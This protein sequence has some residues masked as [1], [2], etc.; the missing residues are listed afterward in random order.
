MH[1]PHYPPGTVRALLD[2]DLITPATREVIKARL[3]PRPAADPHFFDLQTFQTLRAV[4]DRLV[5]QGERADP[6]DLAAALDE[7]L[8]GGMCDGWRYASMPP[9]EDAYVRGLHGINEAAQARFGADF[10]TLD[11]AQ[12]D[13]VLLL[14]QRGDVQGT[15]WDTLPAARF[16]EELLAE[17][18]ECYYS[19]PLTHEEI[20]YVGMA[21]AH[22]W[23]AIALNQRAAHEPHALDTP[24]DPA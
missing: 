17:L 22:G 1:P 3:E 7:R 23:Q 13:Q 14:V 6:V 12:Q 9:D 5:P 15:T 4:C 19:D 16:F 20:G 2:T 11:E 24:H 10:A 8:A 18:C 21:D